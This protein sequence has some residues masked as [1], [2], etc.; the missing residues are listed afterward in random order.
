[1]EALG[2]PQATPWADLDRAFPGPETLASADPSALGAL[3]IVRQRVTALQALAQAVADGRLHLHPAAP[4]GETMQVLQALPGIGPWS[5]ELIALRAL[6]WPDAF[7]ASDLGVLRA[8][9]TRD[10][11]EAQQAAQAWRPWRSYAVMRLW[12]ADATQPLT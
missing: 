4:V 2:E 11:A 5:A 3:G 8:L 10:P 7:P 12:Q 9:G 1:V 6:A